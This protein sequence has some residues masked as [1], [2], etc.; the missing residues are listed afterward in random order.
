VFVYPALNTNENKK[1]II[2][3]TL[4]Y[5]V[6]QLAQ[7]RRYKPESRGFDFLPLPVAERS[8]TDR[9]LGLRVRIP[10]GAW[11]SV[12]CVLYSKD[13]RQSQDNQNKVQRENKKKKKSLRVNGWLSC[14]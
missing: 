5:A 9:L 8:A 13:K 7:A 4:G 12:L 11:K 6:A 1:I 3:L 10:L 2:L 14:K